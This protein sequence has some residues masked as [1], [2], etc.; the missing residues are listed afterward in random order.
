MQTLSLTYRSDYGH[1]YEAAAILY[2]KRFTRGQNLWAQVVMFGSIF[3]GSLLA[4]AISIGLN[5]WNRA[6]P[7]VPVM[8]ALLVV[9]LVVYAK[10][11]IPWQRRAS[12]AAIEAV[13]PATQINFTADAEGL[14]WQDEHIDFAL[15]WSG[16]EALYVTSGAL[17]FMSG[18][19]ALVL[20][21][22]ALESEAQRRE[23]VALC[24]ASMPEAAAHK[25]RDDKALRQL[26][27]AR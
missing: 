12:I 13:S 1:L 15:R 20:P 27:E 9:L 11:L 8:I 24:L 21:L 5:I 6:I 18:A 19:I 25:S 22:A 16:V 17:A 10:V 23:L 4:A 26:L 14:R 3:G 7:M 2:R